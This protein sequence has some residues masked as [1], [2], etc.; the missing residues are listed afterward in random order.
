[1]EGHYVRI[2]PKDGESSS[3]A[4]ANLVVI[5]NRGRSETCVGYDDVVSPDALARIRFGL[6]SA[7]D[8]R[9]LNTVRIIDAKLSSETANGPTWHRY[10]DDG[11]G[12]HADGSAF[13]GTGIGRVWPLLVGERGHYELARGDVDE[14]RRP[15]DVMCRQTTAAA[16][17]STVRAH[18][19]TEPVPRVSASG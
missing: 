18:E 16:D 2:A 3:S 15:L 17:R 8:S 9:I 13:D 10:T 5:R 11:Y 1:V 6:R 4:R 12:E 14:A 19:H 7:S